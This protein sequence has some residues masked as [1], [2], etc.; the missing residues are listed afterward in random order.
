MKS[1]REFLNE[2]TIIKIPQD[3]DIMR[4]LDQ[5]IAML[6]RLDLAQLNDHKAKIIEL[7]KMCDQ[8]LSG[9]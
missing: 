7:H 2:L 4:Q 9:F 1:F 3:A 5:T 6:S 8:K